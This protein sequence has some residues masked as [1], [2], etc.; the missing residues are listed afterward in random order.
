MISSVI[1]GSSN[2]VGVATRPYRRII[3]DHRA[4][5]ACYGA[6]A[7]RAASLPPSYTTSRETTFKTSKWDKA[8]GARL[9]RAGHR[10]VATSNFAQAVDSQPCSCDNRSPEP[11]RRNGETLPIC[12]D[13]GPPSTRHVG[14]SGMR[15]ARLILDFRDRHH[16]PTR[17]TIADGLAK[18]EQ[19]LGG[20]PRVGNCYLHAPSW[21]GRPPQFA[22][23]VFEPEEGQ[24]IVISF[25][26]SKGCR[27]RTS[28][29]APTYLSL[30]QLDGARC[31][32][33]G[34]VDLRDGRSIHTVSFDAVQLPKD[35]CDLEHAIVLLTIRFLGSEGYC[36]R[37]CPVTRVRW[38]DYSTM[39]RLVVNN[40]KALARY[41][42]ANIG[43]LLNAPG[44]PARP[45]IPLRTIQRTLDVAGIR[46]SRGRRPRSVA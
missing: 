33:F 46:K 4:P 10:P 20:K 15:D 44:N 2:Q 7:S 19:E 3:D 9:I 24:G 38:I 22:A 12:L 42:D 32:Q 29:G 14:V 34:N 23:I 28:L 35:F 36:I 41:I 8:A 30:D 18:L 1:G 25:P 6:M 31:D 5:L 27:A 45:R 37:Q 13:T 40:V 26:F 17:C 11:E 21:R 43:A 16:R 39:P